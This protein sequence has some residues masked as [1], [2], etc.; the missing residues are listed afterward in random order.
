MITQPNNI[1]ENFA[2]QYTKISRNLQI[3]KKWHKKIQKKEKKT[4]PI[5]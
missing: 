2:D 4:R 3:K 1:V 5:I